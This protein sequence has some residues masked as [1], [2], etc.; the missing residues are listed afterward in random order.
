MTSSD[1]SVSQ[2]INAKSS[3]PFWMR[4]VNT[5]G[6]L[7]PNFMRPS[8]AQWWKSAQKSKPETGEPEAATRE[9]LSA[10]TQSINADAKLNLIGRIS[11]ADDTVRMAKNHLR[12][13]QLLRE[14]PEIPNTELPEPVFII[15]LPRTGSTVLHL[16]MSQDSAH[17]TIPYWESFDPIPPVNKPDRRPQKVEK[18][19]DQLA[20]LAPDY[21]A[22]H[23]M[24]ANMTEECV[25][26]FMNEMRTLQFDIQYHIPGYVSW[27]LAQDAQIAY[28]FY[29]RQLK[30]I[31][32]FRPAGQR[33]I[34]KD[35]THT[36]HLS[37]VLEVFPKA[38]IIFTHRDPVKTISSICSLY[39][40]T[41]A[42]FSDEVD[43]FDIGTEIQQGYWP[44]AITSS[45][46]IRAQLPKEQY[47]DICQADLAR[48]PMG[49]MQSLYQQLGFEFDETV[50][51]AMQAFLDKDVAK[52]SKAHHYSPEGFG[53][54]ADSLRE[55]FA[56]Y[57]EAFDL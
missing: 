32:H 55:Q 49:T 50:Q 47:A 20:N 16:L 26:L 8:A 57:I 12:I 22:I 42:I 48:D 19:L 53:L 45:Q 7:S 40:H 4:A 37:T 46:L 18:M 13:N 25:A 1:Q 30:I 15:G 35:P 56:D 54:S 14:Q 39:A 36:V 43:P 38:K 44:D 31:Q 52:H 11:A 51:A 6:R 17:R 34:L 33:F 27:L 2:Y 10:L 29:L 23:P 5:V 3:R 21:H 28:Q 41:R 9:A 24:E